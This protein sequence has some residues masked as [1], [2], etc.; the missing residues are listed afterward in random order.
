VSH[1]KR[2]VR[3][4][5]FRGAFLSDAVP[6]LAARSASP[7][8]VMPEKMSF[9]AGLWHLSASH[10]PSSQTNC[11]V[12]ILAVGGVSYTTHDST[13]G[14]WRIKSPSAEEGRQSA[15]RK[16][17]VNNPLYRRKQ[18]RRWTHIIGSADNPVRSSRKSPIHHGNRSPS[19]S[20]LRSGLE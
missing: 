13:F 8:L 5:Y 19:N 1:R 7:S 17:R 15:N 6:S 20:R 14:H 18:G 3:Q 10:S 9:S 16:Y 12:R 4:R 11:I 2:R